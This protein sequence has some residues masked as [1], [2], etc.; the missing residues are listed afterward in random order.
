MWICNDFG[1]VIKGELKVLL[2]SAGKLLIEDLLIP[3]NLTKKGKIKT[4]FIE[5]LK[6]GDIRN[7]DFD[8]SMN[9]VSLN[10]S[11]FENLYAIHFVLSHLFD[12]KKETPDLEMWMEATI[13]LLF[14]KIK[15]NIIGI[16]DCYEEHRDKDYIN[17]LIKAY[18]DEYPKQDEDKDDDSDDY[19][20][21]V[22]K[23]G[24]EAIEDN[25]F[26][27]FIIEELKDVILLDRD[28][29]MVDMINNS[30][31]K[32]ML[33]N[34]LGINIESDNLNKKNLSNKE[35]LKIVQELYDLE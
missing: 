4:N 31:N 13:D 1:D 27:I 14:E 10:M 17:L 16:L 2:T 29:E 6:K 30:T 32:E 5:S 24:A 19:Y 3:N 34:F 25:E 15:S 21:L 23:E 28:Y 22:Y 9:Q 12:D 20:S 35:M 8:C 11:V 33:C 18:R 26:W 7:D